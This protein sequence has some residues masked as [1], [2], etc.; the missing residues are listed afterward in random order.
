LAEIAQ[1]G[2]PAI[3]L[4]ILSDVHG[5]LP[6]LEAV[7]ADA[8]AQGIHRFVVAG[9]T[10]GGSHSRQ[11]VDY[12]RSLGAISIRGNNEDYL[13]V[14]HRGE[15]PP[16][17]Y[18]SSRWC[19]VRFVYHQFDTA[20]LER[21]ASLPE[22]RVV[23]L[24]GAC[25]RVPAHIRVVHGS[26]RS[27]FEHLIPDR[28]VQVAAQFRRAGISPGPG[29]RSLADG[30]EG[31]VEPVLVCGHSHI[32]WQQQVG[33]CLVINPGS[34]GGP[35]NGDWRAQYAILSWHGGRWHARQ[36][37]VP[38]DRARMWR[39]A[40]ASGYLE[41]GGPFARACLIGS[42]IGLN[43]PGDLVRHTVGLA[44]A[45]G[46]T[47]ADMPEEVWERATATFDWPP[48]AFHPEHIR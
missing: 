20:G 45:E 14:Y 37:A 28:D 6:A 27:P 17:W 1:E 15:A 16:D 39:D 25:G 11:A 43:T 31:I 35:I 2:L 29:W 24:G 18:T 4:A 19:P 26:P 5:N 44:A 47:W 22:Q 36:R 3:R 46:Y 42:E 34:V 32:A 41:E 33:S 9:D 10:T 48:S 40:A 30:L 21:L 8:R 13:L 38:Y 23:S 12:L 7:L